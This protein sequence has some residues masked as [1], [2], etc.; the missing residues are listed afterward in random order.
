MTQNGYTFGDNMEFYTIG[1]GGSMQTAAGGQLLT[2]MLDIAYGADGHDGHFMTI[3]DPTSSSDEG[4]AK[5]LKE[6]LRTIMGMNETFSNIVIQDDLSKY[7]DLFKSEGETDL[8]KSAKA[9]V[10]MT[11][12]D[13]PTKTVVLW[14]NGSAANDAKAKFTKANG[15][16]APIISR[17]EYDESKKLV[18]AV[19]DPEYEAVAGIT[20]TLSFDVM[21]SDEAY[22][23][24]MSAGYDQYTSGNSQGH[25]IVGDAD[26]D[27]QGTDPAN[28]TSSGKPGFRSNDSATA[29]Y[30][31]NDTVEQKE[32]P[33]PVIQ[34]FKAEIHIL[35]TDQEG[36]PLKGA[37]FKLYK[38]A[39][40]PEDTEEVREANAANQIGE[41]MESKLKENG[42]EKIA[43]I[44]VKDLRPGLYYLVETYS[45]DGYIKSAPVRIEVKVKTIINNKV[46][47]DN[48]VVTAS[49]GGNDLIGDKLVKTDD[50]WVMK[51]VN[52][53]GATL[54]ATG[55]P[56]TTMF[57]V[58]GIGLIALAVLLLLR[59]REKELR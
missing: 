13:D 40:V 11:D 21:A 5:K 41:E 33:H 45:P 30:K 22:S 4:S 36:K 32:Y 10:T 7:V 9:K 35:K 14:E 20:Y 2:G 19:F 17:L 28:T 56:G 23:T 8:L 37:K 39:Y 47:Q 27:F 55:G 31:H 54:P 12:P 43:E 26:T 59:K 51:V 48:V 52:S 6:D 3:N 58:T 24:F 53:T 46:S 18:K 42:T 15:T 1:F 25:V 57:Y 50:Y 29:S 44:A 38:E 49:V 34:A 16:Q